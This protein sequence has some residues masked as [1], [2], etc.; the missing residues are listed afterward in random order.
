VLRQVPSAPEAAY[1]R[2]LARL[3]RGDDAAAAAD[4]AT[5]VAS[6]AA[7]SDRAQVLRAVEALRQPRW[8]PVGAFG[9]GIVVPGFGQFYTGRSVLGLVVLAGAAAGAGSAFVE[10]SI[11]EDRQFTDPFGNPYTTPVT[12]IERP[13]QTIGLVAGGAVTLVGAAEAAYFAASHRRDRPRLVLRTATMH[14]PGADGVRVIAPGLRV[15]AA[16]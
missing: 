8:S 1:D 13:Y 2:G 15:S 4:L 3:G 11:T 9:R 14:L 12:R 6:P 10:R 5:Y 16:F 7:G